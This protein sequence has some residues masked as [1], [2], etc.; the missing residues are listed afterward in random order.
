MISNNA[1]AGQFDD[2]AKALSRQAEIHKAPFLNEA[3]N[4]EEKAYHQ[5]K[6]SIKENPL[7][8]T[9]K[10]SLLHKDNEMDEKKD[11]YIFVS[12]S[13]P[14]ET[15]KSLYQDAKKQDIPLVLRG[16]MDESFKKT[17][18][19]LG[20]LGIAAEINPQLFK[21]YQIK[22]VPTFLSVKK[23]DFYTLSGNVTLK[24]AQQK[25]LEGKK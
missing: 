10:H 16:L 14:D 20:S 2:E 24:Y 22:R 4:L 18:E 5:I 23:K 11:F 15:L 6:Q 1:L 7:E 21:K 19:H 25:L 3:R 8:N 9:C 12:L 13:I 17:A